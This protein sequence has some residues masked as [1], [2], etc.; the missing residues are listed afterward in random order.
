MAIDQRKLH[1]LVESIASGKF[2]K[3][4]EML[5]TTMNEIVGN[6]SIGING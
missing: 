3:E 1:K 5:I 4:E 2:K 6:E